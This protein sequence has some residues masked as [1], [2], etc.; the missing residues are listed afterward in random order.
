[1]NASL[2]DDEHVCSG[3]IVC[4][5]AQLPREFHSMIIELFFCKVVVQKPMKLRMTLKFVFNFWRKMGNN[6]YAR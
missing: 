1:V 4:G 3:E 6:N 2:F 5:A